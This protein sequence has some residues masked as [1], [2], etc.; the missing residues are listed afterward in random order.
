VTGF[1]ELAHHVAELRLPAACLRG[2][3]S[4]HGDANA[5]ELAEADA[6]F[7]FDRCHVVFLSVFFPTGRQ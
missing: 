2:G 1:E 4:A 7:M 6:G 5:A 3:R